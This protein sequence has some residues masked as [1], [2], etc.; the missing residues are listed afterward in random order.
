MSNNQTQIQSQKVEQF[1]LALNSGQIRAQLKNSLKEKSGAFMSSMLDLYSGDTYLQNCDPM[2]VAM[3]C[4]KA[5]SLDLPIVKSLGFAYV[6]PY[7]NHGVFTPT[8]IIGYKGL[9]QLAQRTGQYKTINAGVVYEGEFQGYD[10][11]SGMV[12]ISGERISDTVVGYF[13]YFKLIN[14]FEKILYMTADEVAQWRA[15]YS[16]TKSDSAPWGTEFDKMAMKTCLRRL[17]SGYGVMSTQMQQAMQYDAAGEQSR[18]AVERITKEAA[19][20]AN[21][22]VIDIDQ[23]TGE[24]I[25]VQPEPVMVDVQ[26]A[27]EPEQM[28]PIDPEF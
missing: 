8:F 26:S 28:P 16:K 25:D 22:T 10:K 3:E 15:R 6:V 14:G 2:A 24:V 17:I 21:Q 20:K 19:E 13:A 1:K 12:D 18:N 27:P 5:A 7:K 4:V 9:I 23:S 11:L